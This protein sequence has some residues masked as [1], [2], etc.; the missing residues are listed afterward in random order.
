MAT[1]LEMLEKTSTI[2]NDLEQARCELGQ[3]REGLHPDQERD[4]C[5]ER[6][7]ETLRSRMLLESKITTALASVKYHEN[8]SLL[9]ANIVKALRENGLSIVTVP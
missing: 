6:D 7:P 9:A 5:Q 2:E 4:L 1:L 8:L 3:Y